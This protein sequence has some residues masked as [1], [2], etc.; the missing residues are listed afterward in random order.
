MPAV[1]GSA[2]GMSPTPTPVTAGL[3]GIFSG[4]TWPLIWPF[5][6][7]TA[8]LGTVWL[9]LATIVLVALPAHAFV[10]G[11]KRKQI[12]RADAIDSALLVRIGAWLAC[13]AATA[14]LVSGFRGSA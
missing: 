11:F 5:F 13:A 7:G 2:F 14:F 1:V 10:L 9:M 12:V 4:L 3:A 6:N 8:A